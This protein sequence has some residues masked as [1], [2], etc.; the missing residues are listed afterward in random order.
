MVENMNHFMPQMDNHIICHFHQTLFSYLNAH[1]I[2]A[3]RVFGTV[4]HWI[5]WHGTSYGL[6]ALFPFLVLSNVKGIL[7]M[8][9]NCLESYYATHNKK[10]AMTRKA[11]V[12]LQKHCLAML[13]AL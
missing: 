1:R 5:L 8:I 9:I 10:A 11:K 12:S 3:K 7:L 13:K 4:E 2:N 6:L